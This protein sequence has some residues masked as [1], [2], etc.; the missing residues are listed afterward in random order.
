[1]NDTVNV[2][3]EDVAERWLKAYE[4]ATREIEETW[5]PHV[6]SYAEKLN[7]AEAI[8]REA[9][10]LAD[11]VST[12]GIECLGDGETAPASGCECDTCQTVTEARSLLAKL[13]ER[14]K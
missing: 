10:E 9:R 2:G 3:W 11:A 4:E 6:D 1:M 13:A 5:K 14:A 12:L 7:Q 8:L